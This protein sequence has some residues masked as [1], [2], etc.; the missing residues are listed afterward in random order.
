MESVSRLKNAYH[1]ALNDLE[2]AKIKI[3]RL[4][5]DIASFRQNSDIYRR[6]FWQ[7]DSD[8][9]DLRK[10]VK[11]FEARIAQLEAQLLSERQGTEGV[12]SS[13]VPPDC[14]SRNF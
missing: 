3:K 4:E 10:Q 12:G 7:Q 6:R 8:L 11:M 5:G 9:C 2:A 1:Q 14:S 13:R